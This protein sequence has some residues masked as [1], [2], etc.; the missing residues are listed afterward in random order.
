MT[1][2][3]SQIKDSFISGNFVLHCSL[4]EL[5]QCGVTAAPKTYSGSGS[6]TLNPREGFTGSFVSL[7]PMHVFAQLMEAQNLVSG[8][9]IPASYFY[10][11]HATSVDGATWTNPKVAIRLTPGTAGTLVTFKLDFVAT[12]RPAS[13]ASDTAAH[14]VFLEALPFPLTAGTR[15]TQKGPNDEQSSW[16]RDRGERRTARMHMK[17]REWKEEPVHSQF[18]AILSESAPLGFENRL[19]EALRFATAVPASWV[20]LE[21]VQ[22]G[23]VHFE[24]S[25]YRPAHNHLVNEP[26]QARDTEPDF[27]RLLEAYYVHSCG[28]TKGEEFSQLSTAIGPLFALKGLDISEISLVIGVAIEALLKEGLSDLEDTDPE[29]VAEVKSVEKVIDSLITIR[30]N[31]RVRMKGSLGGLKSTRAQ[32]KLIKLQKL[33]L[34]TLSELEHWK[35]LRNTSAHG[36]LR[37]DPQKWQQL[38][39]RIFAVTTLAYKL[40]FL[41]IGYFGPYTDYGSPRWPIAWFP[42]RDDAQALARATEELAPLPEA[43]I[44]DKLHAWQA[45]ESALRSTFRE[46]DAGALRA[47]AGLVLLAAMRQAGALRLAELRSGDQGG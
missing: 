16:K 26:L 24:L 31:S 36:A 21:Y 14:F 2:S 23:M 29:L 6:I 1:V 33:G 30:E 3:I 18:S 7:A 34:V 46:G 22:G 25:P 32:D 19:V 9:I 35:K 27:F 5:N 45:V 40:A 8:Q 10:S 44:E 11:L 17:Y 47:S 39:Q 41:R 37:V 12:T 4:I 42:A 38:L 43:D 28:H 13:G 20:M 15:T